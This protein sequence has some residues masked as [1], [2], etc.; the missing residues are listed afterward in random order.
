MDGDHSP[1]PKW[2]VDITRYYP[3]VDTQEDVERQWLPRLPV[4]NMIYKWWIF[5]IELLD[6]G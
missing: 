1:G 6:S 4:R 5:H 2:L 3:R